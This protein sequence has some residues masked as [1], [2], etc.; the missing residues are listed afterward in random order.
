MNKLI[1]VTFCFFQ[2]SCTVNE[3]EITKHIEEERKPFSQCREMGGLPKRHQYCSAEV[4]SCYAGCD[5]P[6]KK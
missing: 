4:S 6:C 1:L 5:F 2:I 3:K